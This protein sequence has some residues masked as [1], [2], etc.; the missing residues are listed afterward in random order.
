MGLRFRK[1]KNYGPFRINFSKS[2][3]G[4]SVG[5]KGF[6]YTKMA[7]GRTRKTYS[8]PGTG[9]SYV[10]ESSKK[11][12]VQNINTN[13]KDNLNTLK[14]D[15][16]IKKED[17]HTMKFLKKFIK[18]SLIL[19]VAMIIIASCTAED[20]IAIESITIN[21]E[22][23]ISMDVN[24]DVELTYTISPI[25][26][27][28]DIKVNAS[29]ADIEAECYDGKLIVS[30]S[31]TEGSYIISLQSDE[32]KSN[33][34]TINVVDSVKKAEEERRQAEL[35]EQ[36]RQEELRQ[37]QLEEQASEEQSEEYVY[38]PS[39]GSKYHSNSS[40]SNMRNPS[41]VTK[42]EAEAQGY[43]PCKKCY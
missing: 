11:E 42:S 5:G 14:N 24:Q 29:S 20:P 32:V 39:S 43:D 6:R 23:I 30:T 3:V 26:G 25:G 37:Q 1:S 10:E 34:I 21:S 40:C 7:N 27:N 38:I 12:K 4:F 36:Q 18:W 15:K 31:D 41:K 8:L 17:S 22:Q 13:S 9:I 35:A 2:G 28:S 16:E 33:E 19:F